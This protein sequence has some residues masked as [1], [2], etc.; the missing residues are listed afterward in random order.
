MRSDLSIDLYS[1]TTLACFH[2]LG[3]QDCSI[4]RLIKLVSIGEITSEVFFKSQ[5]LINETLY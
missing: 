3:K 4:D 1:A 2:L 5:A